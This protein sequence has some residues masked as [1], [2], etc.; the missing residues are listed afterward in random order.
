MRKIVFTFIFL[1]F[2]FFY[3]G[4]NTPGANANAAQMDSD[5]TIGSMVQVISPKSVPLEGVGLVG[6][7]NGKGSSECPPQIRSYLVQYIR[8]ELPEDSGMSA[9]GLIDSLN[10]AVVVLEGI[11]PVEDSSRLYFDIKVSAL[12]GTQTLSLENGTLY[13][14]ELK[15]VGTF[16]I[17]TE[18]LADARGPVYIDKISAAAPDERTGYIL[19]GGKIIAKYVIGLILEKP[20]FELTN[21]IRNRLNMRFNN[22]ARAPRAGMIEVALPEKYKNQRGKFIELIKAMYAYDVPQN[23]Q[24][25]INRHIRQ[26]AENPQSDAGEIALEAIGNQCLNQLSALLKSPDEH[27]RLRAARCMLNLRSDAGISV[28][29]DIAMNKLSPYRIEALNAI[30]E[31]GDSRDASSLCIAL[32]K[33]ENFNLRLAAY[34][35]LRKLN[36]ISVV[37]RPIASD[38]FLEKITQTDKKDIYVSRSEEPVIVL[39]GTPLNCNKGFT[40]Q[41]AD[42]QISINAP[43]DQD[44]V[45]VI[46]KYPNRRGLTGQIRCTYDV[47]DIIQA[48]CEDPPEREQNIRGG[49]G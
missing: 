27:V 4:C 46:R 2:C 44:Y 28:L 33:D 8:S 32:L 26:L 43:A 12:R 37:G 16:G 24:E 31:S 15:Q 22:C 29:R 30:V 17:N 47:G 13:A 42:G 1:C 20:D 23:E 19:A 49:L 6:G 25:R 40:I 38:F 9:D 10:T 41:S 34:E 11:L 14:S 3:A 45:T 7:L 35:S 36:D 21:N 48:L 39:F 5:A 18:V